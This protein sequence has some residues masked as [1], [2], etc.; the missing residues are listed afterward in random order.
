MPIYPT[1]GGGP[2]VGL[3][4]AQQFVSP[5]G[6][7]S[8]NGLTWESAKRTAYAAIQAI[9]GNGTVYVADGFDP[10]GPIPGQGI[11]LRQDGWEIEGWLNVG[12]INIV[13]CG[14]SNGGQFM[15]GVTAVIQGKDGSGSRTLPFI[16]TANCLGQ[17]VTISDISCPEAGADYRSVQPIKYGVD[18]DREPDGTRIALNVTNATRTGT[19]TVL[20]VDIDATTG[21]VVESASRS[22]NVVTMV[23]PNPGVAWLPLLGGT[24]FRLS[25]GNANFP[26]GDYTISTI[27]A[28]IGSVDQ[29]FWTITF[30]D[31][32][33]DVPSEAFAGT[34]KT[35]GC[36]VRETVEL[37]STDPVNFVSTM[38]FVAGATADTVTIF[39]NL[40]T[41]DADED[42]IGT[43]SHYEM[44]RAGTTM[45]TARRVGAP[46]N[47]IYYAG[48][49]ILIGRNLALP[50]LLDECYAQGLIGVPVID[51]A[52]RDNPRMAAVL[53]YAGNTF[54]TQFN[55]ATGATFVNYTGAYGPIYVIGRNGQCQVKMIG[56]AT[57][58]YPIESLAQA[59]ALPG[60]RIEGGSFTSVFIDDV[61]TPDSFGVG[62]NSVELFNC[63]PHCT[64]INR[65]G[66][67]PI[68]G[69][70]TGGGNWWLP[71]AYGPGS[72]ADI[73]WTLR[74]A[75]TWADG[76]IAAKHPGVVRAAGPV[77][78]RFKNIMP[79]PSS[80]TLNGATRTL[81]TSDL[82]APDGT[83]TATKIVS[84]GNALYLRPSAVTGDTWEV[85]G[86]FFFGC[87]I[88]GTDTLD[89]ASGD[90]Y[91]CATA[92]VTFADTN[93]GSNGSFQV[94][95][96]GKGWQY[97]QFPLEVTAVS[98][99]TPDIRVDMTFRN[100]GT[101]YLWGM[102]A[103]YIP[104]LYVDNDAY[105]HMGVAPAQPRYLPK[106]MTGT[107]E[108]QKFIAHGGFGTNTAN[109][110]VAGGGSGQLTLTGAGTVYLPMYDLD[111]TT[112][113]GYI[114]LLQ[115]T[116]NP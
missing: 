66:P 88:N 46:L 25:G 33:A 114:E 12:P 45:V 102:T 37:F 97:V 74:H 111:G 87:W 100:G 75:T 6:N 44:D 39:D 57:I 24:P 54:E 19:E 7:D 98:D 92:G 53:C 10:G 86:K 34:I 58:E 55:T 70:C 62:A 93:G 32:G 91:Q 90:F 85:G 105:E 4:E 41:G 11:W 35:H 72:T 59:L 79:E 9:G 52:N 68:L 27:S 13:G 23:I 81:N 31:A 18:F 56:Q 17:P 99:S 106:G 80:W 115:A 67:N 112:I 29:P 60:V 77:T 1:P 20:T 96:G 47:Q 69:E 51:A 26:S 110:N 63:P 82:L 61:Q 113:L 42:D 15:P 103:Y 36:Q 16:W 83:Q 109:T 71:G 107:F 28:Q 50:P 64:V 43:V 38:Y 22:S 65:A 3:N 95:F 84:T 5:E 76:R 48:P 14:R 108:T 49:G 104:P 116:V 21:Y 101:V 78:A 73:P 94:P 8:N 30:A 2:N 40:I 89:F